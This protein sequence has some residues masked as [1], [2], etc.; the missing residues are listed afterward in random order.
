VRPRSCLSGREPAGDEG[1]AA[2][3]RLRRGP[4]ARLPAEARIYK[5]APGIP[6]VRRLAITY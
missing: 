1:L 2:I 4:R 3:V 6:A 5:L